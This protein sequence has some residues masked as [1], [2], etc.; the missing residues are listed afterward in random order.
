MDLSIF[1]EYERARM[2]S[3]PPL[4]A[5]DISEPKDRILQAAQARLMNVLYDAKAE[6]LAV[7]EEKNDG[8]R[9]V[10]DTHLL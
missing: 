10:G 1:R 7:R 2:F 4:E 5:I 9:K 6:S 8:R 3:I